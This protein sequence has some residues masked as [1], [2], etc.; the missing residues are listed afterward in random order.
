MQTSIPCTLMRGGTS[1][2]AY[3]VATD[4]PS[5]V[6]TRDRVLMAVMGSPDPRQ[7][8]GVGGADPLTSKVAIVS[9]STRPGIDVDYL[10]C[11]VWVDKAE[12]STQQNCGNILA[13][14]APF[15]IERGLVSGTSPESLVRIFMVNTGQTVVATVQTQGGR[16]R[17]DGDAAIDG[18]PGT[19][20]PI[21][22]SFADTAGSTCGA[23][24]PTGRN[25]D[26][27]NGVRVTCIDNGMPVVVMRA[28]DLDRTGYETRDALDNDSEL[29][30]RIEA[31]RLT[32]GP[33]MNLGDVAAK[34][35]PKM[36]LVSPRRA[37]GAISTRSFIPHRCHATIGVFAALSVA[38]AA[39]LP[40]G[41]AREV[42]SIPSGRQRRMLIEH[43]TGSSPVLLTVEERG[44]RDV[45]TEGAIISTARA[46]FTGEVLVP[47]S[48]LVSR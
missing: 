34:T 37:G 6:A 22:L 18:V 44:G 28:D 8:D 21:P 13:G 46:L 12:V 2:G 33:L 35:V 17:Y 25:V 45:V 27:V 20:A 19:A 24:L 40:E 29:K 41:P 9:K 36:I 7:I 31:I 11:Q 43:P 10:F 39:L 1:K 30:A 4:L 26:V 16:P 38:T 47:E 3:F 32:V 23:L 5:D 14:V 42:A 15:A 48:V